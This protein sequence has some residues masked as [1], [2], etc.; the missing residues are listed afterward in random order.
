MKNRKVRQMLASSMAVVVGAG[1]I[2]TCAYEDSIKAHAQEVNIQ[3]L[4]E[5]AEQALGDST[6]KI[7]SYPD[8]VITPITDYLTL[9]TES[10]PI[11]E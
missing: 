8:K 2:G 7:R 1:L 9:V 4:E 5:T 3:K 11:R 6:A 10:Y